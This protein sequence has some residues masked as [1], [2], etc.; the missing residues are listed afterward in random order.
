[1]FGELCIRRQ[2]LVALFWWIG[3]SGASSGGSDRIQNKRHRHCL[4]LPQDSRNHY[5]VERVCVRVCVGGDVWQE[6]PKRVC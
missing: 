2:N 6:V 4:R 1:M 3:N 5:V